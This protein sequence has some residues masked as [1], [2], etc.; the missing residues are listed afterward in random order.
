MQEV[1]FL[2]GKISSQFNN[3]KNNY[4]LFYCLLTSSQAD[5]QTDRPNNPQSFVEQLLDIATNF[6]N[7]YI[8]GLMFYLHQLSRR[9]YVRL[10][11]AGSSVWFKERL[12]QIKRQ[13]GTSSLLMYAIWSNAHIIMSPTRDWEGMKGGVLYCLI[14][15]KQTQDEVSPTGGYTWSGNQTFFLR[16]ICEGLRR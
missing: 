14:Q 5:T 7:K 4:L 6:N 13:V 2:R 15:V 12:L 8:I 9:C 1:C 11:G 3:K 16:W 10:K